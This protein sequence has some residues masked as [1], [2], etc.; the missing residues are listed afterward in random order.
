MASIRDRTNIDDLDQKAEP[1]SFKEHEE[2]LPLLIQLIGRLPLRTRRVLA[3]YYYE[4]LPLPK[5]AACLGLPKCQVEEILVETV[6]L[7]KYLLSLS[8]GTLE[9]RNSGSPG[10]ALPDPVVR[11]SIR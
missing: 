3:M 9:L 4:T 7:L 6:D 8:T 11:H 5:V 1:T 10:C 2:I